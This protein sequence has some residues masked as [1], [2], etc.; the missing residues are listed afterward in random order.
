LLTEADFDARTGNV[1]ATPTA[2]TLLGRLKD[3]YDRFIAQLPAA[4]V[5]GRLDTNIGAWLGST[6]P[7]VGQKTKA[8]S[9]PVTF[10]SDQDAIAI[11]VGAPANSERGLVTATT[12]LGGSTAN[13]LVGV[14]LTPYIEQTT[15]A[16][17]SV[18]STS[19]ND[20]AAG[21]GAREIRITYYD[22]ALAGPFTTDV[23]MNGTT[24]VALSVSNVCFVEKMEVISA[25]SLLANAAAIS[26]YANNLGTGTVIGSIGF[27]GIVSGLGDNR[28]FWGRHYIAVDKTA[29]LATF[30]VSA[31]SGGSGTACEFFFRAR[32]PL[33]ATSPS[34]IVSDLLLSTG[35][36]VRSLSFPIKV[37]GP[38]VIVI[39]AVPYVNNA[40]LNA[41]IDFSEVPT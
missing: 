21:T 26:L 3:L 17:R 6:A 20:A 40:H 13:T 12:Q 37:V 19:A 39:A 32:N 18:K 10:A 9:V 41:S 16:V 7:T 24:A 25:G 29:T 34:V 27:G 8:S 23:T 15:D 30:V 36:I 22:Q 38:K 5:G 4:L 33:V 28:T 1:S 11:F 35:V 2:N 14:D 31:D